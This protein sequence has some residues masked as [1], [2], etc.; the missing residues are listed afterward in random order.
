MIDLKALL[1]L[2]K[3]SPLKVELKNL[4][5]KIR[6]T[7]AHMHNLSAEFWRDGGICCEG[8]GIRGWHDL[9]DKQER[10]EARV[11]QL[12]KKLKII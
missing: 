6:E 9:I 12:K 1:G 5:Q 4:Q 10:R 2:K 7:E 8:C 11:M 3:T